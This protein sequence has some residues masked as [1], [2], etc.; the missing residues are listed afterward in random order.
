MGLIFSWNQREANLINTRR[1]LFRLISLEELS[2]LSAQPP[3]I[4]CYSNVNVWSCQGYPLIGAQSSVYI[5]YTTYFVTVKDSPCKKKRI[6]QIRA[7]TSMIFHNYYN[8]DSWIWIT[9]VWW[10][11][12][13]YWFTLK[14]ISWPTS[15]KQYDKLPCL[16]MSKGYRQ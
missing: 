4:F 3:L 14:S 8:F 1:K 6:H 12:L 13:V 11:F 7:V 9:S 15:M 10:F 16:P 5:F 2:L